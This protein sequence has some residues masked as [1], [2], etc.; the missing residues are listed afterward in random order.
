MELEIDVG[1]VIWTRVWRELEGSEGE[2]G[3]GREDGVLWVGL[4]KR[5]FGG[6]WRG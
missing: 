3:M 6:R 4:D 5:S 1:K 2:G